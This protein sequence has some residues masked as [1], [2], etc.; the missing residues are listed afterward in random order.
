[1]LKSNYLYDD[2]ITIY[3]DLMY[4]SDIINK[5]LYI[6]PVFQHSYIYTLNL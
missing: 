6:Q 4:R 2:N 5:L 3:F 1:M